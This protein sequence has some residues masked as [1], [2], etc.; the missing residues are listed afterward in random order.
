MDLIVF[1]IG[2]IIDD[3]YKIDFLLEQAENAMYYV[4]TDV[5]EKTQFI[6][7]IMRNKTDLQNEIKKIRKNLILIEQSIVL[8]KSMFI[9]KS[10][11]VDAKTQ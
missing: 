3:K 6:L 10:R 8:T 9:N 5:L 11:K 2:D 1:E 7:K 4:V